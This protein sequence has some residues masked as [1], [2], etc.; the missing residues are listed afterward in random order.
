MCNFIYYY[1]VVVFVAV[2]TF[3]FPVLSFIYFHSFEL[4]GRSCEAQ[5]ISDEINKMT[6]KDEEKETV[7]ARTETISTK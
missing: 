2:V 3:H 1:F 6:K 7:N 4:F 5:H